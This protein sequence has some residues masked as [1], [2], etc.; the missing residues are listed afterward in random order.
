MP[1]RLQPPRRKAPEAALPPAQSWGAAPRAQR[2]TPQTRGQ[3]RGRCAPALG[4]QRN[5]GIPLPPGRRRCVP[6]AHSS[7]RA[8]AGGGG[9]AAHGRGHGGGAP[10]RPPG[11]S[12]GG[13]GAQPTRGRAAG[14]SPRGWGAPPSAPAPRESGD[15]RPRQPGRGQNPP[16]RGQAPPPSTEGGGGAPVAA[17]PGERNLAFVRGRGGGACCSRGGRHPRAPRRRSATPRAPQS[18][19]APHPGSGRSARG[20]APAHHP[21]ARQSAP[22][23]AAPEIAI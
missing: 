3:T 5:K 15:A 18:R 23:V 2:Q 7:T 13:A 10:T 4:R 19:P 17:R 22:P 14:T 1:A 20:T 21:A 6:A 8:G 16:P 9:S 11:E 12:P